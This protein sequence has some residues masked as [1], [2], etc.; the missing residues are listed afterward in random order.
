M[1]YLLYFRHKPALGNKYNTKMVKD[2]SRALNRAYEKKT[3]SL[4][5]P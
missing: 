5:F 3:F 1:N 2:I 4:K